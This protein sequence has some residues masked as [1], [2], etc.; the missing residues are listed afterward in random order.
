M[1]LYRYHKPF[2]ADL[3][4][5]RMPGSK[6]VKFFQEYSPDVRGVLDQLFI[7][8]NVE[9]RQPARHGKVIA[10]KRAGMNY[11]AVQATEHLL[12]NGAPGDNGP[13]G[14][15]P[16]TQTLRDSE[17]VGLEIPMLK[18]PPF[19]SAPQPALDLVAHH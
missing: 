10:P 7:F 15:E 16:P 19:P 8:Q 6:R 3:F 9:C 17:D 4:N 12:I 2:P 13:A 1:E 14:N 18:S 11:R 5:Q